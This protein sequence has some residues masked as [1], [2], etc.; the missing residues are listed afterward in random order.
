MQPPESE[1]HTSGESSGDSGLSF[2]GLT[3]FHRVPAAA[4][5]GAV[6]LAPGARLGDVTII[7][8]VDEGGMGRVYEGLQGMTCRT[9]AVKVIKPGMLSPGAARRFE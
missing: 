4:V 3:E 7:R 5:A 8:L 6:D 2:A 9:V 1:V